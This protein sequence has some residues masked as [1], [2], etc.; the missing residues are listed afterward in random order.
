MFSGPSVNLLIRIGRFWVGFLAMLELRDSGM[1]KKSAVRVL[2]E[3]CPSPALDRLSALAIKVSLHKD[4]WGNYD[5]TDDFSYNGGPSGYTDNP[6]VA[7][8][9]NGTLVWGCEP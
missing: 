2:A 9:Q 5:E 6:S 8:Y 4:N 3:C 1:L 7:L